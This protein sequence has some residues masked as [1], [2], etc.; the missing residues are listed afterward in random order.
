MTN[1]G[2]LGGDYSIAY[3]INSL[4][5]V[6]GSSTTTWSKNLQAYVW[7]NGVMT[8]VGIGEAY[9]IN[10][11]GWIAGAR[12]NPRSTRTL[13]FVPTLWKP[14]AT[15]PVTPT[16]SV[17][18]GNSWFY[19]ERNSST[20]VDTVALGSTVTWEW[21]TSSPGGHNVQSKGLPSFASSPII[22]AQGAKYRVSFPRAGTYQYNCSRHPTAMQGRV[23]V[24]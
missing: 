8:H 23:V 20:A 2:T 16:G 4:G 10:R 22:T 9:G 11:N 24:K 5:Q 15:P 13:E 14:S 3:G 12:P 6:V 18:V 1:L 21:I 19:S 17:L 7:E